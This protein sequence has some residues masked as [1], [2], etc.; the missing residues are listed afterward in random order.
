M[1]LTLTLTIRSP[2]A[3]P[4]PSPSPCQAEAAAAAAEKAAAEKAAAEKAAA[5]MEAAK[6]AG[7]SSVAEHQAA[8]KESQQNWAQKAMRGVGDA[9]GKL[10]S[11]I[12][13]WGER[14]TKS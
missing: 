10:F 9:F 2:H 8:I 6:N 11:K 4:A 13:C 12:S 3:Y 7:Y 1:T 14:K 5:E